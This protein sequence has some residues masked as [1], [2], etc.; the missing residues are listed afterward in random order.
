[1]VGDGGSP[2]LIKYK[3][4]NVLRL[5]NWSVRLHTWKG[6]VHPWPSRVKANSHRR[7]GLQALERLALGLHACF[8]TAN[9]IGRGIEDVLTKPEYLTPDVGGKATTQVVGKAIADTLG[10]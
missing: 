10:K 6:G 7:H 3:G 9:A 4:R 5:L 8:P 2:P 1:M